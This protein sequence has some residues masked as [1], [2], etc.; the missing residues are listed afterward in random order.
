M[1]DRIRGRKLQEIRASHMRMK[2]LCVRCLDRGMVRQWTQLD[3]IVPL[4]KGGEDVPSNRQ[5][6]CDPCHAEKTA[7]DLGYQ[8]P[9]ASAAD[10]MP[11]SPDHHWNR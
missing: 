7:E 5:G 3:H 6:L 2:P 10:G 8:L 11:I 1:T 4:F 9:S